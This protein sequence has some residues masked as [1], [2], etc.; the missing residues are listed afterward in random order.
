MKERWNHFTALN[1]CVLRHSTSLA[2]PGQHVKDSACTHSYMS[3]SFIRSMT[4]TDA[5]YG[6]IL[7]PAALKCQ[8]M[9]ERGG[10]L[11]GSVEVFGGWAWRR[12]WSRFES[13]ANCM[14]P[15]GILCEPSV[16]YTA[17]ESPVKPLPA[18]ELTEEERQK[19]DLPH[20]S[21]L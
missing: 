12:I 16:H 14:W 9:D 17:E 2:P 1:I 5:S 19:K 8:L 21:Y 3:K 7:M 6:N 13:Q 18:A 20:L 11:S 15:A 4:H 10:Q